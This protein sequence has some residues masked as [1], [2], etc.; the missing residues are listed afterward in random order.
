MSKLKSL[1][2]DTSKALL[3]LKENSL[4]SEDVIFLLDEMYLQQ[5][6][7][8]DGFKL[9][10]CDSELKMYK[11]ILCFMVVS[12]KQST[13]YILKAIP[14]TKINHHIVQDGILNCISMLNQH[15]N[16]RAVVCDNHSTNVSAYKH[17]KSLYPCLI[18]DNAMTNPSNPEKYTYLIFDTVHRIK[19]IRN[20]LL[21]N[22]F[23]QVTALEMSLMDVTIKTTPGTIQWSIFHR[24]HEKDTAIECHMR[25]AP[26][27]T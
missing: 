20:N 24:I 16:I 10:G 8:Y 17:L 13:P 4:F 2:I 1:S 18:R 19:N 27:I 26:K 6:V 23:F 25:K 3:T 7:Q 12:L 22:R 11:S 15:F 21:A 5:E 9:I 14:L